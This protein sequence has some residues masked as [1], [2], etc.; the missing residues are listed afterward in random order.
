MT[1]TFTVSDINRQVKTFLESGMGTLAVMGEISNLSKPSSG[2]WYFTLKDANAQLRC[3][4]FRQY[5]LPSHVAFAQGTQVI[6]T[7]KL[8]LYEARGDYQLIVHSL[9]EAGI[10]ELYKQFEALKQ[11]LQALGLFDAQHK[12]PIPLFPHRIGLI[13]SAHAAAKRDV[14]TTLARRYPLAE[15]VLYPS[16]VQGKEAP[17]Q[18]C[19]A[20]TEA[21]REQKVEVIILARGGGSIEDLWAFNDE[22]LAHAIFQATIPIITG[23]GHET[24]FTIADFVSDLRAATPTAA[25]VAATPNQSDLIER[26]QSSEIKLHTLLRRLFETRLTQ[27]TYLQHRLKSPAPLFAKQTQTLDYLEGRLQRTL[28]QLFTTQTNKLELYMR[29]LHN[30]SPLQT[31]ERGYAIASQAGN[32]LKDAQVVKIDE[33][34]QV[35]LAKGILSCQVLEIKA[36]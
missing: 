11:K 17:K 22:T 5:H 29:S 26:L 12:K 24:D 31:L 28:K 32:V 4:H 9:E 8:S 3:V 23:I 15:V 10:G 27:L 30:I 1:P 7:G 19:Q 18:L 14:L 6:A 34:V 33:P 21:C 36:T 25:A 16:E 13:T 35:T 20:I 2:H